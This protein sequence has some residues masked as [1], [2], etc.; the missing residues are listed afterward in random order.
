MKNNYILIDFENVHPKSLEILNGHPF[1]VIVFVGA[2]QAKVPF[3]LVMSMQA[4][5]DNAEYVQIAGNGPNALDFHIAFYIG[6][7]KEVPMLNFCGSPIISHN[8]HYAHVWTRADR[9]RSL[10][11][12][13]R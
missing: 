6:Q 10:A 13:G 11:P 2:N 1:K 8:I 4:L 12:W 7:L 9:A 3:E 5:G